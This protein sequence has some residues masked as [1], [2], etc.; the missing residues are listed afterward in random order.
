MLL[1]PTGA[2]RN[3]SNSVTKEGMTAWLFT[4]PSLMISRALRAGRPPSRTLGSASPFSLQPFQKYEKGVHRLSSGR[5]QPVSLRFGWPMEAGNRVSKEA[6]PALHGAPLTGHCL[7]G[8]SLLT[9]ELLRFG[10]VVGNREKAECAIEKI[11][12]GRTPY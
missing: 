1:I 2:T 10:P 9:Q 8:P 12:T 6:I 3:S 5:L 11:R 4:T 7:T